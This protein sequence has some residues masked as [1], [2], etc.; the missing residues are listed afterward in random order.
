[1]KL[2]TNLGLKAY[3]ILFAIFAFSN[4]MALISSDGATAIFYNTMTI[5]F[6]PAIIWYLLA[7]LDALLS[8]LTVLPLCLRAFG[9]TPRWTGLFQWLFILRIICIFAGHRYEYI[10]LKS[11]FLGT[12][13]LGWLALGVWTLFVFPSFKEHYIYAFGPINTPIKGRLS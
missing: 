5:F 6:S 1:M 3:L 8:C 12:P 9:Q 4:L 10:V 7:A 2:P 11:S 13:L